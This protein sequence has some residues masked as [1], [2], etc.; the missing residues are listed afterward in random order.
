[1]AVGGRNPVS[2]W[3]HWLRFPIFIVSS[4]VCFIFVI[5]DT[6]GHAIFNY[7]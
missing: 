5:M 7:H 4:G 1:M 6:K 3:I 2:V